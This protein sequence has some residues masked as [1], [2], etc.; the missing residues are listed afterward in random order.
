MITHFEEIP[1][2]IVCSVF[3]S[4]HFA[5][6]SNGHLLCFPLNK[7][8]FPAAIWYLDVFGHMI[9]Q[10]LHRIASH[11]HTQSGSWVF[12]RHMDFTTGSSTNLAGESHTILWSQ[13]Y[14]ISS[15][16]STMV[17]A[18]CLIW[19]GDYI[20]TQIVKHDCL[21]LQSSF[22][23]VKSINDPS[24][25]PSVHRISHMFMIV[26]VFFLTFCWW[27]KSQ[28][29]IIS[30]EFFKDWGNSPGQSTTV[31]RLFRLALSWTLLN[32]Q[33]LGPKE[34]TSLDSFWGLLS[35][36]VLFL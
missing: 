24:K 34:I 23:L 11:Y 35:V 5:S 20:K 32:S 30:I 12:L 36:A 22:L 28:L 25:I 9:P 10:M 18:G 8:A 14:V 17:S 4:F 19:T 1:T 31:P 3:T 2:Y 15:P 7:S 29:S 13:S 27:L 33:L 6:Q 21:Q 16:T 26:H